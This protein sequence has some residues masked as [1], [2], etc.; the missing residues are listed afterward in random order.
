MDLTKISS[1]SIMAQDSIA[2]TDYIVVGGGTSGP[3]VASRL[4]GPIMLQFSFLKLDRTIPLTRELIFP[5]FG[6]VS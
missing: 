2:V 6:Q 1:L 4:T 3:V 5:R